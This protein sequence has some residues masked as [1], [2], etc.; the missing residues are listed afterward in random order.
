MTLNIVRNMKIG[1]NRY[2][3]VIIRNKFI[4]TDFRDIEIPIGN[5]MN[6]INNYLNS[7][8]IITSSYI[9]FLVDYAGDTL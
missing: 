8:G 4:S 9:S 5:D 6:E 1:T 3:V 2:Q 7:I